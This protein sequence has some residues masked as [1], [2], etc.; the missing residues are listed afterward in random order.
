[1]HGKNMI[2]DQPIKTEQKQRKQLL[3]NGITF[4]T[5]SIIIWLISRKIVLPSFLLCLSFIA[6]FG[7]IFFPVMGKHVYKLFDIVSKIISKIVSFVA[8]SIM[9]IVGIVIPGLLLRIFRIDRL[10]KDFFSNKN[11]QSMFETVPIIT[12]DS[13]KRQS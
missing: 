13:F 1:M 6:F 12:S 3:T 9:Y 5:M 11:K 2:L 10:Q 7:F 8:M 4:L